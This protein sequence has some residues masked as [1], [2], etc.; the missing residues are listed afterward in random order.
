MGL[1]GSYA[2]S[3]VLTYVAG[4]IIYLYSIC[5]I[6][7]KVFGWDLAQRNLIA[8]VY[9]INRILMSA[10]TYRTHHYLPLSTQLDPSRL[11]TTAAVVILCVVCCAGSG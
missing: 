1:P 4:Q 9:G 8:A 5:A 7:M 3:C 10:F 11:S 2:S 6:Y